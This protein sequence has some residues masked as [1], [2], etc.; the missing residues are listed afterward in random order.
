M[1]AQPRSPEQLQRAVDA[2]QEANGNKVAAS[3]IAGENYS[4]YKSTLTDAIGQGY[5]AS[6]RRSQHNHIP[7]RNTYQPT[8]RKLGKAVRVFIWGCAHDCPGLPDKSRF[9]RAGQLANELH[10]DYIVDLGDT[11][12]MDSLSNHAV[13]GSI[14]DRQRSS[15]RKEIDSL[16]EAVAAF[17]ETAPDPEEIPRYHLWGNHENRAHRFERNNPTSEGVYTL[18]L[19]QVFARYGFADMAFREWLYLEGVGFTH[20][21]INMAGREYGGVNA[22]QTVARESTHSVVWAHTHRREFVER[23]KIGI[24]NGVQVFNTGTFMPMGL[25]KEYAGLS[26]TGWSY[27]VHELTLRDGQIESVRTWSTRELQERFA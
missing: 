10:P 11:L 21:P 19:S 14:E 15:F 17:H 25:I 13:A 6:V 5:R 2:L 27:G 8:P 26:Q 24:G 4:T 7:K 22:N 20:A 1:T 18:P 9:R 23:P 12:D 16:E 3:R